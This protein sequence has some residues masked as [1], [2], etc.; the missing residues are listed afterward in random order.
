MISGVSEPALLMPEFATDPVLPCMRHGVKQNNNDVLDCNC[1]KPED[2]V[3]SIE[4]IFIHIAE[5]QDE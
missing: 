2:L 3:E 1:D 4:S 5:Q